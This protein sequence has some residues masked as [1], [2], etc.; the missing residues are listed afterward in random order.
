[1]AE[2]VASLGLGWPCP[3]LCQRNPALPGRSAAC[4]CRAGLLRGIGGAGYLVCPAPPSCP[5]PEGGTDA[6]GWFTNASSVSSSGGWVRS[7]LGLGPRMN[8]HASEVDGPW[9]AGTELRRGGVPY[10]SL[11][12][13][14]EDDW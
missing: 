8:S 10:Q 9:S 12:G 4:W 7:L 11:S 6:P 3:I 1:M 14:V 5:L 2:V 13:K